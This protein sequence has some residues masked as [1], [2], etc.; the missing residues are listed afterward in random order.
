MYPPEVHVITKG[1]LNKQ[2]FVEVPDEMWRQRHVSA[3]EKDVLKKTT[4][5]FDQ[6]AHDLRSEVDVHALNRQI[7]ELKEENSKLAEQNRKLYSAWDNS[8]SDLLLPKQ[9]AAAA[10]SMWARR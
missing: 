5:V 6:M 2:T 9:V 7:A 3:N 4:D 10:R 8:K 1:V